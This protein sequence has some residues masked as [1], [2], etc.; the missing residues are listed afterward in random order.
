MT[1]HPKDASNELFKVMRDMDKVCEHL[2]LPLQSGSDRILK[3]MNSGYTSERYL[4][5]IDAYRKFVPEASIT[6][7][8]MVGF[9]SETEKDFEKTVKIVKDAR[10]DSAFLFNYS[11]RPPAKSSRLKDDVPKETKASRFDALLKLQCDISLSNN[12][13]MIGK[14]V[15]VLVDGHNRKISSL[16]SGRTRT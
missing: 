6:T 12:A 1:S 13:P 3:L 15:E 7:D 16:V 10:F 8:I 9:P 11:P 14:A 5:L 4:E 2:H